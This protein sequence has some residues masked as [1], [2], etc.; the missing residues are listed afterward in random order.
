MKK[1]MLLLSAGLFIINASAQEASGSNSFTMSVSGEKNII[2]K[3]DI[4]N[5]FMKEMLQRDG[6][7]EFMGDYYPPAVEKNYRI[8]AEL[9]TFKFLGDRYFN[10]PDYYYHI[11]KDANKKEDISF[12][13]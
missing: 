7:F 1:L 8:P 11:A 2:L 5:E 13:Y 9:S 12:N 3:K 4:Q 10:N 6:Y